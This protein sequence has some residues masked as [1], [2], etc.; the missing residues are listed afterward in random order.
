M[1][2]EV[3]T[4]P[5]FTAGRPRLLWQG[6]YTHGMSSSCGRPGVT[7]F[8]YDVTPDGQRFLMVKDVHQDVAFNRIHVVVNWTQELA[9]RVAQ[10]N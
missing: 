9:R 5:S 6:H 1:V 4:Q 7:S 8:N 10:K 2:L 3:R